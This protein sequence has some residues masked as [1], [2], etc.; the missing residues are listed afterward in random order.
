MLNRVHIAKDNVAICRD[1]SLCKNCGVCKLVCNRDIGVEGYYDKSCDASYCVHCGQCV[2]ACPFG[3]LNLVSETEQVNKALGDNKKVVIFSISPAVRVALGEL[4][5]MTA[6]KNVEGKIVAA[7]KALGADYVLD[8]TFG[9]DLTIME[10]TAELLSRLEQGNF[11]QFTS[12]CPAWVR[13]VETFM[14]DKIKNLSSARS[15]IG[16]QGAIVKTYF[17]KKNG[18]DPNSIFT[19][20]VTPCTAKKAEIRRPENNKA[21]AS[22]NMPEM[23][24]T[25]AVITTKELFSMLSDAEVNFATLK[26]EPFDRL[27]GKGSGAGVIFGSTG[28][29]MEAALRTAYFIL[30][31]CD[32]PEDFYNLKPIRGNDSVREATVDLGKTK[33]QVA[34]IY[35]TVK[36]REFIIKSGYDLPQFIEVMACPGG[37]VGGGGQPKTAAFEA[38]QKTREDRAKGL[39]KDDKAQ[40]LKA[41]YKNPEILNLYREF[42][43]GPLGEKSEALL[44]TSYV[45]RSAELIKREEEKEN[46]KKFVCQVCGYVHEGTE[47]PEECPVCKAKK[48]KFIEQS[49]EKTWAAEH[50]VGVAKGV[51]ADVIEGLRENF[52]G[53]CCEVGMYLAMA[54]VAHREG[55]PEIG[56]YYEKAAYE[57]AEHAAKFAE[58]LGEVVTDS[59]KKNLQLRVDAE[60]GATLGKV[61]LATRA[62]E[63][64]LDAIH[65]TVHE[66]ARDEARHGKAFEGL[67]KR[68]FK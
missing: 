21:G 38:G 50:V 33:L 52:N 17:A 18:I 58:L 42:L 30:N 62:K 45:N 41:S 39:Y 63:L 56:M 67:L 48:E 66:M 20:A 65:D 54:R 35:G 40:K 29:V 9:A 44:H 5:G 60:N 24:D 61:K 14:P 15:P 2:Q 43:G 68:Y 31:G 1:E 10:E 53:E 51:P 26:D 55:Y 13:Y 57:E 23:R 36:A 8:T 49:Q 32:A 6:G 46:M 25:D 22:Q 19:V 16:M 47:A 4:Y 11:P 34:A 27:M 59:T 28:G 7:L 64:N 37:C 12:C 3:A